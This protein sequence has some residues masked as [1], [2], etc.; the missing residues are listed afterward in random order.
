MAAERYRAYAMASATK[1]VPQ[2]DSNGNVVFNAETGEPIMVVV[3][4]T[5][6]EEVVFEGAVVDDVAAFDAGAIVITRVVGYA[7]PVETEAVVGSAD[8]GTSGAIS[9]DFGSI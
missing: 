5:P 6:V 2:R 1:S 8:C 7:G 4:E 3:S 9:V